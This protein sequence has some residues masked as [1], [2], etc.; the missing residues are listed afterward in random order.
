MDLWLRDPPHPPPPPPTR[1]QNRTY[2]RTWHWTSTPYIRPTDILWQNLELQG[3]SPPP[4][5]T[6]EQ[7]NWKHNLRFAAV[8]M[9]SLNPT[10]FGENSSPPTTYFTWQ[11]IGHIVFSS[12]FNLNTGIISLN[13]PYWNDEFSVAIKSTYCS[14]AQVMN[15]IVY[16]SLEMSKIYSCYLKSPDLFCCFST[17]CLHVVFVSV[18]NNSVNVS[19]L[20]N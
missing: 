10:H 17:H 13:F 15:C 18:I 19:L 16:E 12:R 5:P 8:K 11:V 1:S 14:R 4:P 9:K 2:H 6:C 20:P 7:T 3:Q